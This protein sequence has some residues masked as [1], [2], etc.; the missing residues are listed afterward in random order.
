MREA[1]DVAHFGAGR[2]S[3]RKAVGDDQGDIIKAE[4]DFGVFQTLLI[5]IEETMSSSVSLV[6]L[7]AQI[8]V[9]PF[10]C[11]PR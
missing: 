5:T 2:R 11:R 1:A 4:Q 9:T 3:R 7:G 8:S 6:L 10:S